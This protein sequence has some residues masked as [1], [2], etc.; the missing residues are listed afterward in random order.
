MILNERKRKRKKKTPFSSLTL[1][2]LT[3]TEI[4][5]MYTV[6][7]LKKKALKDEIFLNL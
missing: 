1:L 4:H 6:F 3:F 5:K 7:D 2:T